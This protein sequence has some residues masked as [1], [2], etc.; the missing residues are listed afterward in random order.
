MKKA[1][2]YLENGQTLEGQSFGQSG[3][4]MGELV[5]TTG[6]IGCA[7]A[8][9]DPNYYGQLVIFTF[10]QL[11]NCGVCHEDMVSPRCQMQG[12]VVRQ[13]CEYPSNFRCD[14][15]I[16]AFLKAQ[17]IVGIAGIDTRFLTQLLRDG[18]TLN[19]VISTEDQAPDWDAMRAYRIQNAVNNTAEAISEVLPAQG[20]EAF[21]VALLDY[22]KTK[23]IVESL[24]HRGCRVTVYPHTTPAETILNGKH[25]GLVCSNGPGDP[26]ENVFCIEQL[27]LLLGKLP[28]LG[29]ALGHELMALAAGAKT[30]KL[31]FGHHGANQ[32]V[33]N[34][35]TGKV[36][37]TTQN[38]N[39]TVLLDSLKGTKGEPSFLNVNDG[40][41]EGIDYPE[42]HAFSLQYD[43]EAHGV[44]KHP[45][46][47]YDRF[48]HMMKEG[49]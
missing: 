32:P 7:E 43:P 17:N 36:T 45:N 44:P 15:S 3:T 27:S 23:S 24:T 11:G 25:D 4:V 13:F 16:D 47:A 5:F 33:K 21:S 8:L 49:L 12:V 30:E 41:C 39:Y 42:Y 6:M 14:E 9:T 1:Y 20:E 34:L 18:G 37:I 48:T 46:T 2:L 19:A 29:I 40:S 28:M 31:K 26:T 38:H 22:G 35:K 10:P